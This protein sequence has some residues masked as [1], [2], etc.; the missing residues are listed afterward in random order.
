MRV[1]TGKDIDCAI[2]A[3]DHAPN[4]SLDQTINIAGMTQEVF[5]SMKCHLLPMQHTYKNL[6]HQSALVR[7]LILLLCHITIFF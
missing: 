3:T 5:S 1:F 6:D 2:V 7:Q 4:Y